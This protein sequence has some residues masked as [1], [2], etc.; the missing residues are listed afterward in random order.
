M[1]Y[2]VTIFKNITA[3]ATGFHRDVDFIFDR[4]RRGNSKALLD[5]VQTA[6]SKAERNELKK[7]LPSICFSGTFKNR[8]INGLIRHSGL[9]CLDFDGFPNDDIAKTWRD[10]LTGW[11][12]TFALFTSPSGFGLKVIVR[13]P[14]EPEHH[15]AYFDAIADHFDCEYFDRGTSDVS[16]VCY[17]SYDP[18]IYCNKEST[19]WTE[20]A[21]PDEEHL[22]NDE[23][24][25]RV[26]SESRIISNLDKWFQNKYG[27]SIGSRNN[28]LYRFANALNSFGVPEVESERHLLQYAENSGKDSF[29]DKEVRALVKSAYKKRDRHGTRFFEDHNAKAT[30]EKMVRSGAKMEDIAK[31]VPQIK[32]NEEAAITTV[33]DTMAVTDFWTYSD[34]G[35]V[36]LSPHKY[37]FFLEQNQFFKFFPDGA[38]GYVFVQIDSNLLA[39]TAAP[40]IKDFVLG[41]LQDRTDLGYAPFDF[42]ANQTRLFKD[43]YLSMLDTARVTL[44][45]DTED[46]CYLY[47]RN[48]AVEVSAEDVKQIDYIDLDGYVWKRHVNDRDFNGLTDGD[49][50]GM[51]HR[52]VDLI[53]GRDQHRFNSL[54]SVAGYLLH[55]YKT[56][57]NNKAIIFNDE[58]ISENPNGGSG[59]GLF[60][61]AI[62]AMKRSC[63]LDGK[64]F[65]FEKSFPYQTV[66]ADTQVL[67][68]DDVRKNFPFE[69][70]F[71]LITEGITL[72]KKN[73]DAIYI[74]VAK[75][76]KIVINTNYT[77]GGV[78]GSFD[79]RK[80]EV[81]LSSYFG[82]HRTP[83]QEFGRM[84]F[85]EWDEKEWQRFDSFMIAAV[86][87]YLKNGLVAHEFNN[88]EKRKFIKETGSEFNEWANDETLPRGIRIDKSEAYESFVKEY[89]DFSKL[90]RKRFA[91][92]IEAYAANLGLPVTSG[93]SMSLRWILIGTDKHEMS[94]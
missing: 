41:Y 45:A 34:S 27:R 81:E 56:S 15:K 18:D 5:Q 77:I 24:E 36:Q 63:T 31:A 64:Q 16:R 1:K 74:P 49:D 85:D 40:K 35:K 60:C 48:C 54:L 53:A 33:K 37:K 21:E 23:V 65:S 22:G 9:M 83:Y 92:W 55:S 84:L 29:T 70:L 68:F 72:E 43:D 2:T 73:K 61:R 4:I 44:K 47:F 58:A 88:L 12:Y 94:F 13:I 32:G 52:F 30:I 10:T 87:F 7:G 78:G 39:D 59:K 42:M 90:S 26:V 86:Q 62:G 3:T 71:S 93:K 17:E 69:Q 79:R 66:S 80:F 76:P 82:A 75:S 19:I 46:R 28:N 8:S 25:I 38:N 20:R 50:Y 11:E 89:P 51:F 6:E 14:P 91:Q 67:I 57:A